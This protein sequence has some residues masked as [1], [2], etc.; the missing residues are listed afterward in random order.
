MQI[1]CHEIRLQRS[2]KIGYF[3]RHFEPYSAARPYFGDVHFVQE[4]LS[5][6]LPTSLRHPWLWLL[7]SRLFLSQ[8]CFNS[9]NDGS[10]DIE[11]NNFDLVKDAKSLAGFFPS[12]QIGVRWNDVTQTRPGRQVEF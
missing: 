4:I 2:P 5:K 8:A 12:R 11:V 6:L 9:E 10:E 1:F 3:C 7:L